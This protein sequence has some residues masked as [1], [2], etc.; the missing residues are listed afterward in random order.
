MIS[1]YSS[2]LHSRFIL[3]NFSYSILIVLISALLVVVLNTG[4]TASS[5]SYIY[6]ST[7]EFHNLTVDL[8]QLQLQISTNLDSQIHHLSI[9][10]PAWSWPLTES[11]TLQTYLG[12]RAT[13]SRRLALEPITRINVNY[14]NYALGA[15]LTRGSVK[16]STTWSQ[17]QLSGNYNYSVGNFWLDLGGF[18]TSNNPTVL[19]TTP[20]N[21]SQKQWIWRMLSADRFSSP[22]QA[23]HTHLTAKISYKSDQIFN[24][25][26]TISGGGAYLHRKASLLSALGATSIGRNIQIGIAFSNMYALQALAAG[27][28]KENLTVGLSYWRPSKVILTI[29]KPTSPE[30]WLELI[31]SA[32]KQ[33]WWRLC[34]K[35]KW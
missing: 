13:L 31:N 21:M 27:F 19:P 15:G 6:T 7:K 34:G 1:K 4:L 25:P 20:L 32:K 24:Y 2:I 9:L 12:A 11:Y 8:A 35:I 26:V 30:I 22:L 18:Y 29:G 23:A 5:L 33:V 17:V 3:D 10:T 28:N 14:F 16:L